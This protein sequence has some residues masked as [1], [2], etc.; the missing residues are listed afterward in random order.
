L[1]DATGDAL[2]YQDHGLV[3]CDF[4]RNVPDPPK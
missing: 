3:M 1:G 2:I 4:T